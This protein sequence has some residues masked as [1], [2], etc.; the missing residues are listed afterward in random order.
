MRSTEPGRSIDGGSWQ[1]S[2]LRAKLS[3]P[4]VRSKPATPQ[5]PRSTDFPAARAS[6]PEP[7]L[8]QPRLDSWKAIAS[9]LGR[10]VRTVQRWEKRERLPVRRHFHTKNGTV[11]AF[12]C[13]IDEWRES[14]CVLP[15]RAP[16]EEL[17]CGPGKAQSLAHWDSHKPAV[18]ETSSQGASSQGINESPCLIF[19]L[20]FPSSLFEES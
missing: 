3:A 13:E 18:A 11:Y 6:V 4:S 9:Y 15:E 12:R 19:I 10:E 8:S 7:G 1:S 14:R 2:S 5:I 17:V 16:M 20:W